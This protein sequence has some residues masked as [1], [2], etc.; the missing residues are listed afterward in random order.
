MDE[1]LSSDLFLICTTNDGVIT[2]L[3]AGQISLRGALDHQNYWLVETAPDRSAMKSWFVARDD[4]PEEYLPAPGCGLSPQGV[5]LPDAI[6]QIQAFFAAKFSGDALRAGHLSFKRFKELT[7][8]GYVATTSLLTPTHLAGMRAADVFDFPIAQPQF[9]GPIISVMR[10]DIDLAMIRQRDSKHVYVEED[11]IAASRLKREIF[12]KQS[13]DIVKEAEK[14]DIREDTASRNFS[15]IEIM[16]TL[17]PTEDSAIKTTE[18][19]SND[20]NGNEYLIIEERVAARLRNAYQQVSTRSIT[21]RGIVEE[22]NGA[23][24]TFVMKDITSGRQVTC[25]IGKDKF[26]RLIESQ[27]LRY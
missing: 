7:D 1:F 12:F 6:R 5:R 25:W 24:F 23:G 9:S 18:F 27:Q 14:G 19:N 3:R 26:E 22:I 17:A 10:P 15:L 11:L 13:S 4:L 8:R 2:A 16:V 20:G 21:L